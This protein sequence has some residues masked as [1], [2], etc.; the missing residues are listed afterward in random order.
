MASTECNFMPVI[1]TVMS[2]LI[3]HI[4]ELFMKYITH[5]RMHNV[6]LVARAIYF[7]TG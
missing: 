1:T 6:P 7:K 4:S 2:V 5:T 3:M